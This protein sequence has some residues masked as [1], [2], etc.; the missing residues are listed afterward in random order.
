MNPVVC[1][2]ALACAICSSAVARTDFPEIEPNNSKAQAT[3]V[4]G[5]TN[6]DRLT[7]ITTSGSGVG[8]DYFDLHL[9]PSAPGIYRHRLVINSPISGHVGTIRGLNQ[10]EGVIGDSDFTAQSSAPGTLPPFFNQWYG[11]GTPGQLYYRVAGTADT[12]QPYTVTLETQQVTPQSLGQFQTGELTITT[13]GLGHLND[14]DLWVYDSNFNPI[15][16]FGNDNTP[17][18]P[19][20]T[21]IVLQSTLTRDFAPGVYYLALSD[22]NFANN[23]ASPEDD[24][25]RNGVVLDFGGA[26][27]NSGSV[28]GLNLAFAIGPSDGV[29]RPFAAV[30]AGAYDVNWYRF[31]VVPAPG[32]AALLG[33]AGMAGARRRR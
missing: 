17:L 18:L 28:L 14:T 1:P 32:A 30:K 10:V 24:E 13:V 19:G 5:M 20:Q 12:T 8:F 4:A 23:L 7:G 2:Y 11:F 15:A 31:E 26:A 25:N 21:G 9:A 29:L 22:A 33:L 6:G 16:D 3:F 27:L